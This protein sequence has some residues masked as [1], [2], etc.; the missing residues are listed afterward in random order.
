MSSRTL[1]RKF[2]LFAQAAIVRHHHVRVFPGDRF[3]EK[4]AAGGIKASEEANLRYAIGKYYD[5]VGDFRQ[6]FYSYERA[7]KLFKS[8][9][10]P[11]DRD[12]HARFVEVM[13]RGHAPGTV[14]AGTQS[15]V[16]EPVNI[17][18]AVPSGS[19]PVDRAQNAVNTVRRRTLNGN[20]YRSQTD[21]A[22]GKMN[23]S[24]DSK[25]KK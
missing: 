2:E 8:I 22:I 18:E 15:P 4:V 9:A 6:A 19:N 24:T 1:R 16:I 14:A 5:D 21:E 3:A 20:L 10:E 11:Y 13:I 23:G 25:A 12:E 7:N 17:S